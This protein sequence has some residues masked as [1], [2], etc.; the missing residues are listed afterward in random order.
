MP[1]RHILI[2]EDEAC[3]AVFLQTLLREGGHEVSLACNGRQALDALVRCNGGR[4]KVDI[5]LTDIQM[6]EIDGLE[7]ITRVR[8]MGMTVGIIAMS[9]S[10][11]PDMKARLMK[12]NVECFLRKPFR[13]EQLNNHIRSTIQGGKLE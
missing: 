10:H 11:D 5:L 9:G 3:L 12:L 2:A 13:P 1:C 7:L 4:E 6:P 8:A